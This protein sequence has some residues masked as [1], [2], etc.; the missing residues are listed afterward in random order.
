MREVRAQDEIVAAA[1]AELE[2]AGLA[3][4]HDGA[5]VH[6]RGDVLDAGY[7]ACRE[8]GRHRIPVER[9]VVREA[10]GKAAVGDQTVGF[11]AA[12]AQGAR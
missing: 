9:A 1:G 10:Q 8:I 7:R 11:P 4:D 2:Q 12:R 5:P 6:V 3:A